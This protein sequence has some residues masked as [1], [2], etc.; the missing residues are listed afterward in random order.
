MLPVA[1][2]QRWWQDLNARYFQQ[3]LP[4]IIIEWSPRLTSSAGIFLM[5]R[6]PR[7]LPDS[8]AYRLIRLSFPLLADQPPSEQLATLAHEMIHQWQY[9]VRRRRPNHGED[10]RRVMAEMNGDGLGI[11]VSHT[12]L[13]EVEALTRYSW[14]CANCGYLYRRHRR[15]IRPNR[16]RC[17]VCAGRLREVPLG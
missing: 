1:Q 2:L 14:R 7:V 3:R 16:H 9:D 12:L 5:K 8:G 13:G 10:F 6:G 17:G 4:P 11:T 15:T